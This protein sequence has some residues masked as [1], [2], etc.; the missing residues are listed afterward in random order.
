[1]GPVFLTHAPEMLD[2]YYGERALAALRGLAEIRLNPTGAVLDAAGLAEHARGCPIIVSDRQTAAPA[3]FFDSAPDLVAFLR[4]AVDIRNVD[5]E[6]ASRSGVLVARATPGFMAA[7]A[8]MAVGYMIDLARGISRSVG[9][10]RAGREAEARMGRQLKGSTLG[11]IGYGAISQELAPV[12]VALGM[13]VLVSDPYKHVEG[14]GLVQVGME[15]LLAASDFVVCLAVATAETENLMDEAAF[16]RMKRGAFFL[17]LARGNLVDEAALEKALESGQLAGAALDVGRAPDQ[18][19]S[20]RLACRP[21]V[22]ATPH[23]A[24]L[25][26]DAVEHQAFDTVE[27]V[28]ALLAGRIPAGAANAEAASRLPRLRSEK[29]DIGAPP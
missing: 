15:D 16:A 6:A 20:P 10:Y 4:C 1:M 3:A 27:Q 7:V 22:I 12:A 11:L 17:N 25:T 28:R 24:G 9:E 2:K 23:V 5:L 18:K 26:P 21:D 8:E 13:R 19:P 14:P 29:F